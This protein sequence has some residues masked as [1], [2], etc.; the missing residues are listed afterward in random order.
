[1]ILPK[2]EIVNSWPPGG[3]T[4]PNRMLRL[5][6]QQQGRCAY[7]G[8]HLMTE[9]VLEV[10]HLDSNRANNR[11]TN[12]ALLHTHCHDQTHANGICD[13]DPCAEEPNDSKGCA[14]SRTERIATRGGRSS[15]QMTPR[16]TTNLDPKGRGDRSMYRL[17]CSRRKAEDNRRRVSCGSATPERYG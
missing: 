14:V 12:V 6:K 8:L 17:L 5:L 7:C 13:K 11:L 3:P 4:K 9:D 1:M 2:R 10:H 16:R 15:E